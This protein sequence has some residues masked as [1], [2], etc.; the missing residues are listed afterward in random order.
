MIRPE[1][2]TE[3]I[4]SRIDKFVPEAQLS[5]TGQVLQIGDGISRIYGLNSAVVGELLEFEGGVAGMVAS[6]TIVDVQGT[7]YDSLGNKVELIATNTA[8]SI[9]GAEKESVAKTKAR[10]P[11]TIRDGQR[12]VSR[13]DFEA[14]SRRAAGVGRALMLTRKQDPAVDENMG[15]LWIVPS[16]VEPST[17]PGFLTPTIRAAIMAEFVKYPY[18][19]SFYLQTMD[20]W[21]L[22]VSIAAEVYLQGSAKKNVVK[23]AILKALT[24]FFALTTKDTQGNVIDNPNVDFGYYYQDGDGV[25]TGLLPYS[26]LFSLVETIPGV[27]KIGGNPEDFLL[28]S[29][30]TNTRGTTPL[31]TNV[32]KDL[33]FGIRQRRAGDDR[34]AECFGRVSGLDLQRRMSFVTDQQSFFAEHH[35][36]AGF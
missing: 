21:Y 4:K 5:E 23:T 18:A 30:V 10:A 35:G 3:I 19:P 11:S 33:A 9:G 27:R 34:Q 31:E 1:E 8:K 15:L 12:T 2:I 17:M 24:D 22:D 20:P 13:E 32:H 28:S 29:A 26:D 14:V 25:P 16:P 36:G 7:F 6:D